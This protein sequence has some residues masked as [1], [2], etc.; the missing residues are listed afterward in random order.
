MRSGALL[1]ASAGPLRGEALPM[2]ECSYSSCDVTGRAQEWEP[3]VTRQVSPQR[4]TAP[5]TPVSRGSEMIGY[6][7]VGRSDGARQRVRAWDECESGEQRWDNVPR[8]SLAG[9]V[10]LPSSSTHAVT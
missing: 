5:W 9:L 2:G 10:P 6:G 8:W 4:R 7:P 1:P 3:M